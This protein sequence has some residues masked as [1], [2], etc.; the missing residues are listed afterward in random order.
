MIII[1]IT[2]RII[3]IMTNITNITTIT[4]ILLIIPNNNIDL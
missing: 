2:I 3:I 1:S 4:R